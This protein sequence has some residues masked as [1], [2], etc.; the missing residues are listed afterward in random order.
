[1][2]PRLPKA[3]LP[4]LITTDI[5][6]LLQGEEY[7]IGRVK[8]YMVRFVFFSSLLVFVNDVKFLRFFYQICSRSLHLQ[9]DTFDIRHSR[10]DH[11]EGLKVKFWYFT[12]ILSWEDRNIWPVARTVNINDSCSISKYFTGS[13]CSTAGT[14]TYRN[15]HTHTHS[16]HQALWA[17]LIVIP[18]PL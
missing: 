14:H 7:R 15:T 18:A 11:R 17:R 9:T 8:K 12:G 2:E 1:M 5:Y 4:T 6:H 10:S 16:E 13:H 3:P